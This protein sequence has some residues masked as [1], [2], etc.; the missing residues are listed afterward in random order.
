MSKGGHWARYLYLPLLQHM[1]THTHI[2]PSPFS[3]SAVSSYSLTE[4]FLENRKRKVGV[5]GEKE[6][7]PRAGRGEGGL[8]TS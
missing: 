4:Q 1:R 7:Q 5:C 6:W 8:Q 3:S 2:L